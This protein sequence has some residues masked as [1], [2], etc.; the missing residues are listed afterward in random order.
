MTLPTAEPFP[1]E[2]TFAA[3]RARIV[4]VCAR[5]TGSEDAA[6]DLAQETLIE[7]W[8]HA[9]GLRNPE[10]VAGWLTGIARNV[11]LRWRRR[12]GRE[13][14]RLADPAA[15]SG[16]PLEIAG[17]FDM[18]VELERGE[19]ADLLDRALGLLPADTRDVLV[20][21]FVAETPHAE[22]AERMQLSEGAVAMRVQRGKLAL[23]RLLSTHLRDEARAYGLA[24]AEPGVWEETKLWCPGCGEHRLLGRL[25]AGEFALRCPHCCDDPRLF[26][27]LHV[28]AGGVLDGVRGFRRA[29]ARHAAW[30]H[31]F[32]SRTLSERGA[33]CPECGRGVQ[34]RLQVPGDFGATH[35]LSGVNASCERCRTPRNGTLHVLALVTPAGRAF[36]QAERRVRSLP[37][38][39]VVA[40]ERPALLAAF[41]SVTSSARLEVLF[42]AQTYALIGGDS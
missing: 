36:W 21:R 41:E 18:E 10:A 17:D 31:A 20:Q 29:F 25:A 27:V 2:E 14:S 24:G 4:R 6:E 15:L 7:A 39:P 12:V 32:F 35:G 34:V 42:D 19:L 28:G 30:S 37:L 26:T 33:T 13:R 1:I 5:L 16:S 38:L 3:H 11:C 8:R 22:I 9:D 40:G 23:R